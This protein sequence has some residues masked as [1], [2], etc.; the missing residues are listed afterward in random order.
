M[1]V[2]TIS[3]FIILAFIFVILAGTANTVY[4]QSKKEAFNDILITYQNA[5]LVT[6]FNKYGKYYVNPVMWNNMMNAQQ[7]EDVAFQ[8]ACHN[9]YVNGNQRWAEIY[10][11]MSGKL[12]AKWGV[13]GFKVY[14]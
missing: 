4:C 9:E 5:G 2:K 6:N 7:K 14:P 13:F 12:I 1:I 11:G 8:F 10:D 3:K